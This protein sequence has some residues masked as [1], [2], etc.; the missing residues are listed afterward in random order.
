MPF[1]LPLQI[2]KLG[3][4]LL[5]AWTTTITSLLVPL[6]SPFPLPHLPFAKTDKCWLK[7]F[8]KH[9]LLGQSKLL[10]FAIEDLYHMALT[11]P[12]SFIFYH[13]PLPFPSQPPNLT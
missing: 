12:Y 9:L 4:S 2:P 5:L 7:H 13:F 8:L 10:S 11:F 6:P 1:I 3:L